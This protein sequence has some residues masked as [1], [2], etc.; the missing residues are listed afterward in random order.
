MYIGVPTV[1]QCVK[2]PPEQQLR[3]LGR[4]RFTLGLVQWIKGSHVATAVAHIQS[5]AQELL[6]AVGAAIKKKTKK[7]NLYTYIFCIYIHT[8][9]Y[10][11]GY[12]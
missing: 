3:S 6:Y 1:A 12:F 8:H 5:L 11:L 10:I 7:R 2:N 4:C 9:K